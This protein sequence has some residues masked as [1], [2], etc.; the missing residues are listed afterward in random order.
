MEGKPNAVSRI[1]RLLN[2]PLDF[3]SRE[4]QLVLINELIEATDVIGPL[5]PIISKHQPG[6]FGR[7]VDMHHRWHRQSIVTDSRD[8]LPDLT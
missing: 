8:M 7:L 5:P 6:T 3:V 2:K 4:E 1:N